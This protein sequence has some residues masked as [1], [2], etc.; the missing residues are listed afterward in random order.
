MPKT[1]CLT[2]TKDRIFF[3]DQD[4]GFKK[5]AADGAV[6][7]ANAALESKSTACDSIRMGFG[8]SL[9]GVPIKKKPK[10]SV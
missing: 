5:E 2:P 7:E 1:R 10:L 9:S 4:N 8:L 6:G 3:F